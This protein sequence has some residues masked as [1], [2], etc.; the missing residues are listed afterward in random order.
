MQAFRDPVNFYLV[1]LPYTRA[2]HL[3]G[4]KGKTESTEDRS[5]CTLMFKKHFPKAQQPLEVPEEKCSPETPRALIFRLM[6]VQGL[7]LSKP[8]P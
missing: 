3:V 8:V 4:R 1:V 7:S 5:I 2:L 6:S